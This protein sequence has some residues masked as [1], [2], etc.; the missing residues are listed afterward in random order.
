MRAVL[1]AG[2]IVVQPT[3]ADTDAGNPHAMR[4]T[5][6][7]AVAPACNDQDQLPGRLETH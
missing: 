3:T 7:A 2:G 4:A 5:S 1:L 6:E